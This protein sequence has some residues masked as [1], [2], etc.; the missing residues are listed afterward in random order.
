MLSDI[1]EHQGAEKARFLTCVTLSAGSTCSDS[2]SEVMLFSFVSPSVPAFN[3]TIM[4]LSVTGTSSVLQAKRSMLTSSKMS[5]SA[6]G[7]GQL[8]P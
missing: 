3:S 8:V 7:L 4:E 1:S 2:S 6:M 5:E